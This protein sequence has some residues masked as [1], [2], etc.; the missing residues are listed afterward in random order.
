M[1]FHQ[2]EQTWNVYN[3]IDP[4]VWHCTVAS[5]EASAKEFGKIT[6]LERTVLETYRRMKYTYIY[7]YI[8]YIHK[9][10]G[11]EL[12]RSPVDMVNIPL[13]FQ[14]FVH[15]RRLFGISHLNH[16]QYDDSMVDVPLPMHLHSPLIELNP[17]HRLWAP[18]GRCLAKPF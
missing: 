8:L 9:V 18:G 13:F 7:I 17:S 2:L 10:D 12:R 6:F 11:S 3:Y 1:Q 16:Q 4:S 14:G 15:P 5:G